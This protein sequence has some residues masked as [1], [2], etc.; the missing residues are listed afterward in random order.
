MTALMHSTRRVFLTGLA[1]SVAAA[2]A[3]AQ[4]LKAEIGMDSYT[5]RAFGWKAFEM[6]DY[7]S[8][9]KIDVVQ[10]SELPHIG[11]YEQAQDEG[12]LRK[13]KA[14]AENV[15]VRIELGTWGVCPT[16]PG[17]IRNWSKYGSA[18]D[19]LRT[20]IRVAKI[21]DAKTI[22]CVLGSGELRNPYGPIER[23]M[24]STIKVLKAVRDDALR[25]G[26]IIAP[27][28]HK[29]MR[30]SE[31][32][33]MI[34]QAGRDFVG[35]TVDTGNPMEVLEDPMETVETLAPVAVATHFRDSV[36][37][38]HP[39]GAAFQWTAMGDGSVRIAEVAKR[40]IELCPGKPL[41]LE[42]ITGRA[43]KVLPF[44]EDDF[45]KAFPNLKAEEFARFEKLVDRGHPL[46]AG[47]VVPDNDPD[48]PAFKEAVKEQQR[49]DFERSVR[50]LREALG[51][52]S[53]HGSSS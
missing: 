53:P 35:A 47:M 44:L 37:F 34:D 23:H 12:Y 20:M 5:L 14:H 39:R 13:V 29:D 7:L 3:A 36:L 49:V 51:V 38:K 1:A 6:L 21:L 9:L 4:P 8:K 31:M 52:V 26:V 28:N 16:S 19:Q 17:F 50:Y 32:L 24:D 46:M 33:W 18:E 40:Y 41:I 48:D 11:E 2:R 22:R 30:A 42:I 27:E 10:F 45:W 25:A 15:G 43:P